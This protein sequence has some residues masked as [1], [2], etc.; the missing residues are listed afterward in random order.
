MAA[1][2]K[3]RLRT[4]LIRYEAGQKSGDF[5]KEHEQNCKDDQGS[6]KRE[7]PSKNPFQGDI[8][9]DAFNN[10]HVYTHRRG[11]YTHLSYEHDY[12]AEPDRVKAEL[13]DDWI[14]DGD[15]DHD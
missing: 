14:E 1:A 3:C 15:G 6:K 9:G 8:R 2:K 13:K 12:D 10:K 5:W 11:D 4:A 7:N